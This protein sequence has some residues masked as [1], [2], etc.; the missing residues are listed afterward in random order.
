MAHSGLAAACLSVW[1]AL[2]SL[3]VQLVL[4]QPVAWK[5]K[6]RTSRTEESSANRSRSSVLSCLL[7]KV[8]FDQLSAICSAKLAADS[9]SL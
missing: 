1:P 7:S 8:L 3:E 9:G 6:G 4:L 2:R 5:L